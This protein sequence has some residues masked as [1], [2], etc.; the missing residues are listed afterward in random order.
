[1][2]YI[3][4]GQDNFSCHQAMEEIKRE[5]GNPEMLAVNTTVLDG[6]QLS[7]DQLRGICDA[8]PFLNSSRL[9]IVEGL[10]GCFEF[11]RGS[12]RRVGGTRAKSNSKLKEWQSLSDYI[13]EMPPTTVLV[14]VDGKI[15][16]KNPLLKQLSSLA[17]V[18][19]FPLLQG[20]NLG[21]WIQ[22]RIKDGDGAISAEAVNLLVELVGGDLWNMSS[23]IDKLLTFS[24]GQVITE[25]NVRQLTSYAREVNIFALIDAIFEGRGKMAQQLLHQLLRE[26]FAP[27]H[28]LVMI[29]RQLRLIVRA[30]EL[31][32]KMPKSQIGSRLGLTGD[33]VLDIVLRQAKTYNMEKLKRAYHKVLETDIAIKT[34]MRDADLAVDLLVIELCQS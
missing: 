5:L 28:I 22:K 23:E 17:K 2:L 11:E 15:S 25:D 32:Q 7:F 34:G 31:S 3:I 29:T 14:L 30:K 10:L 33:Y 6:Q 16:G 9:V 12:G 27:P 21:K 8:T 19:A 4:F 26:G 1:M 24:S 13:K 20:P 18:K